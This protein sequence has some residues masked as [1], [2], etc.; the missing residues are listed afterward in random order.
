[1][2]NLTGPITYD[3][4]IPVTVLFSF[5]QDSKIFSFS[6]AIKEIVNEKQK[7]K[8]KDN[9]INN[10]YI[11]LK[12]KYKLYQQNFVNAIKI[13][14]SSIQEFDNVFIN[15]KNSNS[16]DNKIN[17]DNINE[18]NNLI[19]PRI[20]QYLTNIYNET[21]IYDEIIM[22]KLTINSDKENL[23]S[24]ITNIL[25]KNY[26]DKKFM[27]IVNSVLFCEGFKNLSFFLISELINKIIVTNTE[28]LFN[29]CYTTNDIFELYKE[30]F[31]VSDENDIQAQIKCLKNYQIFLCKLFGKIDDSI[32]YQ[33][34]EWIYYQIFQMFEKGGTNLDKKTMNFSNL[35]SIF[36]EINGTLIGKEKTLV[37]EGLI[38]LIIKKTI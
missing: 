21:R 11:S 19:K 28:E 35:K 23:K 33:N 32:F 8:D 9:N 15:K 20:N 25:N 30:L 6:L 31:N 22:V 17:T 14:T 37:I 36:D 4:L 12:D 5:F 18:V 7:E 38:D 1:M 3:S 29:K 2:Q 24:Y 34:T 16:N 13:Y 27:M 10:K 26:Q